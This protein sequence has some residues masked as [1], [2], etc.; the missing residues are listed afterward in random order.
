[1]TETIVNEEPD[2]EGDS[3]SYVYPGAVIHFLST[4]AVLMSPH[5]WTPPF[6]ALYGSELELTEKIIAAN[7]YPESPG[8]WL[9]LVG[10]EEGQTDRWGYVVVRPG[11]WPEGVLRVE[12]GSREFDEQRERALARAYRDSIDD[13]ERDAN[14]RLV[15][16]VY[17][18]APTTNKTI[19]SFESR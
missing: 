4:L 2:A 16:A 18:N 10:D 14:L 9:H 17:G 13:T 6:V 15:R 12:P 8:S 5:L 19:R 11:P 1:M 7:L 3:M